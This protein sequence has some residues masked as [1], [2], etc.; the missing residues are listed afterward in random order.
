M[1]EW[2]LV[3]FECLPR[4]S[5]NALHVARVNGSKVA[6]AQDGPCASGVQK[7]RQKIRLNHED[8]GL[9]A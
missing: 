9:Y 3:G 8:I 2:V 5:A 6:A 7:A 1:G 4:G